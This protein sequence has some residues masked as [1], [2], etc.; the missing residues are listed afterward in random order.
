MAG[1]LKWL[2]QT[3]KPLESLAT[4]EKIKAEMAQMK[5]E[6]EALLAQAREESAGMLKD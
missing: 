3:K 4:A 5:S 1:Y 2:A 6:N